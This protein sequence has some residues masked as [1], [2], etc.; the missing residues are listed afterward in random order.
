MQTMLKAIFNKPQNLSFRWLIKWKQR[1]L[2]LRTNLNLFVIVK[3]QEM[4]LL[5]SQDLHQNC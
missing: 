2:T 1:N 4:M 3:K 5:Y